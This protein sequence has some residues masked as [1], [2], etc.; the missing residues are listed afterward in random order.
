MAMLMLVQLN[1]INTDSD[2]IDSQFTWTNFF[3]PARSPWFYIQ[4]L[5]DNKDSANTDFLIT[6]TMFSTRCH[7][8]ASVNTGCIAVS[9]PESGVMARRSAVVY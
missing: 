8:Y 7:Q 1:F 2:N 5:T 3:G 9:A 6:H 4:P